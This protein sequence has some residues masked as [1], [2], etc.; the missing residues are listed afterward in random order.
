MIYE[1]VEKYMWSADGGKTWTE[2]KLHGMSDFAVLSETS[3]IIKVADRYFND[4]NYSSY[5]YSA[6]ASYQTGGIAADLSAFAGQTVNVTIAAVPLNDPDGLCLLAH[7][8]NVT[9]TE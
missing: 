6:K 9:V 2:C 5:Q 8:K 7:I 1:G 3:G 4:P